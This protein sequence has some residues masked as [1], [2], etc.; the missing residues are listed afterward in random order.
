MLPLRPNAPTTSIP[1]APP[2]LTASPAASDLD[3]S[4]LQLVEKK[5]WQA[6]HALS[7]PPLY[8]ADVLVR[9]VREFS[10]VSFSALQVWLGF[11][12]FPIAHRGV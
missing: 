4:D 11:S 7:E 12:I 6:L 1:P 9:A 10:W 2:P 8:G 3:V 5:F